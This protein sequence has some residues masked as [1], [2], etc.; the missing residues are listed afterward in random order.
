MIYN[1]RYGG[2][3]HEG[4]THHDRHEGRLDILNAGGGVAATVW[5][6][7]PIETGALNNLPQINGYYVEDLSDGSLAAALEYCNTL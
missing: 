1:T 2:R 3:Y 5:A 6:Y 4:T 7:T